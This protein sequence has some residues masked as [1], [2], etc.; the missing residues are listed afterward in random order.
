MQA[1]SRQCQN[2]Q[3]NFTIEPEDFAFYQKMN[4]P[5][6]TFCAERRLVRRLV[7]R[8]ERTLYKRNCDLCKKEIVS[9]YSTDKPFPV[10]CYACWWGDKWD[11]YSYGR[12]IDFSRLFFEQYLELQNVVPRVGLFNSNTVNS[13]YSNYALDDKNCYLCFR[14]VVSENCLYVYYCYK[15]KD[16]IDSSYTHTGEL[17]YE[18]FDTRNCYNSRYLIDSENCIDSAYSYDLKNCSH[19]IFSSNLRNKQYYVRNKQVTPEE[20]KKI[21]NDVVTGSRLKTKDAKQK[22]IALYR[23]KAMH[24]YNMILKSTNARGAKIVN[25]KNMHEVYYATNSENVRYGDD[26]ESTRDSMDAKGPEDSERLYEICS[27]DNACYNIFFSNF[28]QKGCRD[29]FYSSFCINSQNCFGSIGLKNSE[30]CILNKRYDKEEY[31]KLK[32]RLIKHMTRTGE[33]GENF[34]VNLSPF[35]YNETVVM[36][37]FPIERD[38][39]LKKGYKWQDAKTGTYGQETLSQEDVPDDIKNISESIVNEI[40]ACIECKRNYRLTPQELELYKRLNICIPEKCYECR[41]H[42]RLVWRLPRKLWTRGC[43]CDIKTHE[44]HAGDKCKNEFET[45][46]APDRPE[47]IYCEECYLKEV[48]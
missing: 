34:P 2:C 35:A 8:N 37:F 38:E 36:E 15:G 47:I 18:C 5:P 32:D 23:E 31:L 12:N 39:A 11:P 10:Y 25:S 40:L 22:L 30:Y 6:P 44:I 20:F 28:C 1:T 14:T 19:C 16:L 21:W 7:L 45:S 13:E 43:V 24:R 29:V 46:Y 42:E 26:I 48:V 4:V 33:W 41:Y 17:L 3:K 9:M 27:I